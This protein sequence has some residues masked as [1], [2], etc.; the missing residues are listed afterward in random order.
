MVIRPEIYDVVVLTNMNGDIVSDLTSGLVG[1]LGIAPSMNLGD[2]A[3]MFE[4]VHGSAP[5]IAGQDKV[6]PTALLLFRSP[7]MLR[8]LGEFETADRNRH[9]L[10]CTYE[11]SEGAHR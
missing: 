9:A 1:G 7:L 4:A 8:H 5:D 10:Y 11:D 3:V 2:E 6:N